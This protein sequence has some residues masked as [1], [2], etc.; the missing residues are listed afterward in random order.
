VSM[1]DFKCFLTAAKHLN[2]TLAAM[3]VFISQP[4]MSAKISALEEIFGVKL[5]YRDSHK[6][7][8][9]P[10]GAVVYQE[11]SSIVSQYEKLVDNMKHMGAYG[12][13]HLSVCFHGPAEWANINELIY[14]FHA[15]YPH[16][17]IDIKIGCWGKLVSHLMQGDLDLIFTEQ[18]EIANIP[19]INSVFLF[20]DYAALAVPRSSTLAA[21][22]H[23]DPETL[24]YRENDINLQIVIENE[25]SSAKSMRQI[26]NRLQAAGVDMRNPKYVDE[27]AFAIAMVSSNLAIAPIPRSFKVKGNQT[28]SY[29]DI[30][31]D[32]VYL[33]F[34][35][36]WM[37]KNEKPAISLF[38][39]YCRHH[40]W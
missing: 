36:A 40:P 4:A 17:E 11:L 10:A 22:E 31:S 29:V 28:V 2:F 37:K 3:E 8:L 18:A 15:K 26:Y 34:H 21:Y 16:I 12:E 7:E 24:T 30:D 6:V 14:G 19:D 27:F 39:D 25:K 9:T 33:D 35:L 20:R 13:N 38:S 32:K 23:I 1:F 5:F